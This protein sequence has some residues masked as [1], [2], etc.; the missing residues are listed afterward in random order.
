MGLKKFPRRT[1]S[2]YG[3]VETIIPEEPSSGRGSSST[4]KEAFQHDTLALPTSLTHHG[5][6]GYQ[7]EKTVVVNAKT[8]LQLLVVHLRE[9]LSLLTPPKPFT[10]LLIV[11]LWCSISTVAVGWV[12][13]RTRAVTLTEPRHTSSPTRPQEYRSAFEQVSKHQCLLNTADDGETSARRGTCKGGGRR[14]ALGRFPSKS[15]LHDGKEA[16]DDEWRPG[17]SGDIDHGHVEGVTEF[18]KLRLKDWQAE[19]LVGAC[20]GIGLLLT[21]SKPFVTSLLLIQ[22]RLGSVRLPFLGGNFISRIQPHRPVKPPD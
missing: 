15:D 4:K 1:S 17:V 21:I 19:A 2:Q 13:S 6:S 8:S 5:R 10:L 3:G 20:V 12:R 7:D 11:V 18:G 9:I 22:G 16:N 14:E